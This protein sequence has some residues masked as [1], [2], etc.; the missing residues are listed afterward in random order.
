MIFPFDKKCSPWWALTNKKRIL[1]NACAVPEIYTFLLLGWPSWI[2]LKS[3]S[4]PYPLVLCRLMIHKNDQLTKP[5][6]FCLR[7]FNLRWLWKK[8]HLT[9]WWRKMKSS[10]IFA[11]ILQLNPRGTLS[12]E[13]FEFLRYFYPFQR[14]VKF[15]FSSFFN[16]ARLFEN[17]F[18]QK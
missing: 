3:G 1:K 17:L 10:L 9:L 5:Y 14:Y 18:S 13:L 15:L 11:K 16:S 12:S 8:D 6:N 2:F 4:L 7:H